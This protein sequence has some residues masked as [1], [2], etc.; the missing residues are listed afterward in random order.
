MSLI[1]ST[2]FF[3]QNADLSSHREVPGIVRINRW[4]CMRFNADSSVVLKQG[5][6]IVIIK[7]ICLSLGLLFF[8]Y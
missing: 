1:V 8:A 7:F 6:F 4:A 2:L 3:S 5:V